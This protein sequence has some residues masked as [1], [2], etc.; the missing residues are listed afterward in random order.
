MK[1]L[2][3]VAMMALCIGLQTIDVT[4]QEKDKKKERTEQIKI[5]KEK[6]ALSPDQE[7]KFMEVN[8]KYGS[9]MKEINQDTR[10][11]KIRKLKA[12]KSERDAEM[13]ILLSEAQY[14]SYLQI[15]EDRKAKRKAKRKA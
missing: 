9:K 11:E 5:T 6:L 2:K 15:H 4:A 1:N 7:V 14:K 10:K 13:K 3:L 12:I 8:K